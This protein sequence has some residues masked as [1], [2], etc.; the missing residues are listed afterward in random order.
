[1][2]LTNQDL[3]HR[4]AVLLNTARQRAVQAVNTTIV[5]T[6]FEIGRMIVEDEQNGYKRT[7][8]ASQTLA[9]LSEKLTQQFGKGFSVS[10]LKNMRQFYLIYSQQRLQL[11]DVSNNLQNRQ[12]VSSESSPAPSPGRSLL[13]Q[14]RP[15][16]LDKLAQ[17]Q[18]GYSSILRANDVPTSPIILKKVVLLADK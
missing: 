5:H 4:V 11:N 6:Y 7:E 3:F 9:Y 18:T 16:R 13:V 8:Y 17:V 14:G 2:D 12:T 15:A 10:N 1:M